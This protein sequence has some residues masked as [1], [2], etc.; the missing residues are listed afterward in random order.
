ME[1]SEFIAD[2]CE[3]NL[4]QIICGNG[5]TV[6]AADNSRLRLGTSGA[7][8]VMEVSHPLSNT[9]LCRVVN[10]PLFTF[11]PWSAKQKL[12]QPNMAFG[13]EWLE[14]KPSVKGHFNPKHGCRRPS[15][16]SP[17]TPLPR[18]R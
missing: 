4:H 17:L 12:H 8:L 11:T 7:E 6:D 16:S 5:A 1:Y 15:F 14:G 10:V 18:R 13:W 3:N 9:P 2:G